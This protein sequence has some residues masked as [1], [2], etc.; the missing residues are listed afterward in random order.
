MS[1]GGYNPEYRPREPVVGSQ[2]IRRLAKRSGRSS[3]SPQ[4]LQQAV[5]YARINNS[6]ALMVWHEGEL[7]LEQYF[8]DTK[9]STLLVSKSLSK[10]LTA[11]A[12]G[13]AIELGFIQSLDQPVSDHIQEWQGGDKSTVLV[14]HLL[15]MTAGFLPQGYSMD[16]D[17]PLNRA[18]FE[19][20]LERY[21]VDQYPLVNKPGTDYLY[22]NA[23]ANM[24]AVLIERASGQRYA[25]FVGDEILKPIGAPGGEAWVSTEGGLMHSG[26]CTFLPAQAW[27]RLAVLLADDGMIE[28]RRLLPANYVKAMRTPTASNPYYGLGVWVGGDY[29]ERRGFSGL[30]KAGPQVLHS[31]PYLD[32]ELYLF[33]GNSNQVVYIL[34]KFGL[35]ILRMGRTP[36]KQPEWDNARLPNLLVRGLVDSAEGASQ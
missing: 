21:L 32:E 13:R 30:S 15:D 34:P 20:R 6:D 17:S 7:Q 33:D 9:E 25:D 10:P 35:V 31:E 12:I 27:L 36:P 23:T 4:A 16:P 29:I 26:C 11:I 3:I 8:G 19:P 18:L 14:R 24:V 2:N 22:N 28:G 5:E 1:G